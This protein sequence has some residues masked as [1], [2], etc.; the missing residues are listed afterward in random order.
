MAHNSGLRGASLNL[1]AYSNSSLR[2]DA[3]LKKNCDDT[4]FVT[5]IGAFEQNES[6]S[7][8][9]TLVEPFRHLF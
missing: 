3:F 6:V 2:V 5:V 7:P 1:I 4:T 9:I 8:L